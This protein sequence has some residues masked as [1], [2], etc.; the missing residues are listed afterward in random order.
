MFLLRCINRS[1]KRICESSILWTRRINLSFYPPE[2]YA[3]YV[4]EF[5]K[6]EKRYK[7]PD[8]G[9]AD[10][11]IGNELVRLKSEIDRYVSQYPYNNYLLSVYSSIS[12]YRQV[13][14][15]TIKRDAIFEEDDE[16][17]QSFFVRSN[18]IYRWLTPIYFKYQSLWRGHIL[19]RRRYLKYR[20]FG[21]V[22]LSLLM[23]ISIFPLYSS[24]NDFLTTPRTPSALS[25]GFSKVYLTLVLNICVVLLVSVHRFLD[26]YLLW[27]EIPLS[28]HWVHEFLENPFH[29][30]LNVVAL[31][32]SILLCI[33]CIDISRE[34]INWVWCSWPLWIC[35]VICVFRLILI[36][37]KSR[38]K[39]N[40]LISI[41]LLSFPTAFT[42]V[43]MGMDSM[44][45]AAWTLFLVSFVFIPVMIL[46]FIGFGLVMFVAFAAIFCCCAKFKPVRQQHSLLSIYCNLIL[47]FSMGCVGLLIPSLLLGGYS[48]CRGML[49]RN[50]FDPWSIL[51]L[52]FWLYNSSQLFVSLFFLQ[53]T[54]YEI[55]SF[56]PL[57]L[58]VR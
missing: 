53:L 12:K 24:M 15:V 4:L 23:M 22:C 37:S 36:S 55:T 1:W 11:Q 7:L 34:R 17:K 56:Y 35:Y 14:K 27:F 16:M 21:F 3:R 42:I 50:E 25:S 57:D 51:E 26:Y 6:F 48:G 18:Q 20:S 43:M 38:W 10:K 19:W 41:I 54:L 32:L 9:A 46:A 49:R 13:L 44:I 8:I 47:L 39:E 30:W 29:V 58:P 40:V 2:E 31:L 5:R 52:L 28:R 45:S 33:Y